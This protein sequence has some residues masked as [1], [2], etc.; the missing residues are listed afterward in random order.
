MT[1]SLVRDSSMDGHW[2]VYID[3]FK[4]GELVSNLDDAGWPESYSYLLYSKPVT[5]FCETL[6]DALTQLVR[7]YKSQLTV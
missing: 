2:F 3:G 5:N 4:V 6:A 7:T 1:E